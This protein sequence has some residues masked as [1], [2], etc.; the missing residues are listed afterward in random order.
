MTFWSSGL[1]CVNLS[2]REDVRPEDDS[3]LAFIHML[4]SRH[5]SSEM[6]SDFTFE[7][8]SDDNTRVGDCYLN[9]TALCSVLRCAG[10]TEKE[11]YVHVH[12]DASNLTDNDRLFEFL[13]ASVLLCI[14]SKWWLVSVTKD[15]SSV[16]LVKSDIEKHL[17]SN[18]ILLIFNDMESYIRL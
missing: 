4:N 1:T 5:I 7:Y 6:W 3:V 11:C 17:S 12:N 14:A 15:A 9:A 16:H 13:H 2:Y 10:F 8:W 18:K